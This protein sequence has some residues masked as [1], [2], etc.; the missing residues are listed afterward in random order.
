MIN[1]IVICLAL[2]ALANAVMDAEA[3]HHPRTIWGRWAMGQGRWARFWRTWSGRDSWQNK[4]TWGQ[5][6]PW[7]VQVMLKTALVPITDLWHAA[8]FAFLTAMQSAMLLPALTY[9]GIIGPWQPWGVQATLFLVY[10]I[11]TK[12]GFG[13]IFEFFYTFIFVAMDWKEIKYWF[14]DRLDDWGILRFQIT[15]VAIPGLI[16]I[17]FGQI[18]DW[19]LGHRYTVDPD[20]MT[21]GDWLTVSG[22]G[23]FI[24]GCLYGLYRQLTSHKQKK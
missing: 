19:L 4:H 3:H 21:P 11:L 14:Q 24:F 5:G 2:A 1:L 8:Q 20:H 10:F 22:F 18:V 12:G 23:A 15:F 9:L 17:F 7:I 6:R 16:I 13:L